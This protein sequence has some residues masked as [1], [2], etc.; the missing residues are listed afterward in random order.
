MFHM[1]GGEKMFYAERFD[2]CW[3]VIQKVS[4]DDVNHA[5]ILNVMLGVHEGL[6]AMC[7][8]SEILKD[9]TVHWQLEK[10]A[11]IVSGLETSDVNVIEGYSGYISLLDEDGELN[12]DW[13]GLLN[14]LEEE[15]DANFER[16]ADYL[17]I[18]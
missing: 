13:Q 10:I 6:G 9:S 18:N 12:L 16:F 11:N 2:L 1:K 17:Y 8:Q 14:T 15:C 4:I 5:I 7:F 3:F